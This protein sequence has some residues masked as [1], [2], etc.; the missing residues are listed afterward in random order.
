M[1]SRFERMVAFRYLKSRRREGFISVI[2]AF[3]LLGIALGV[4]TLII[5]MAVMNG[6][7]AE[8]TDR[9]LGINA[10]I[11]VSR[12]GNPIKDYAELSEI[13]KKVGHVTQV[14][15]VVEGQ[16]MA[17]NGDASAGAL[18]KG[19]RQGDMM[20]KDIVAKNMKMGDLKDFFGKD[21]ALIGYALANKLRVGVG[22]Q[23]KLIAP[24]TTQTVIG[25]IPRIK[26]FTVVGI[27]D[28]GMYEYDSTYVFIPLE[29]AQLYFRVPDAVNVIE[30][31]TDDPDRAPAVMEKALKA[32][33]H[34]VVAG[35][36]QDAN[37][38]FFNSL[39]VER[40]VMFLI[41]ALIILVA[42]FN[43][44]SSMIMM[45]NDKHRAIAILRTMGA[46]RGS[47][48][49][50]FFICGASIG[51]VGTTLGF[52]LGVGFATNIE[53]IRHWLE[54]LTGTELFD[55]EIYFLS[56]LPAELQTEDVAAVVLMGLGLSLLATIYPAWKAARISPAEGVRYE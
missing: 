49:K 12:F 47:I 34:S 39:E 53:R 43:I 50:I 25:S 31:I 6:F 17:T 29:A 54:S 9:I 51:V 11:A 35:N 33:D 30:L 41:L 28:V 37:A 23:V 13:F 10:H 52:L 8:L 14:M 42:A 36:W 2:A 19:M 32:V 45:V 5:V 4:A 46:T 40:R 56:K 20:K 1:F 38:H 22:D 44:I 15:P 24:Q 7:R 55:K 27:F 3:S 48:L 21:K 18:V 26:D 16:A